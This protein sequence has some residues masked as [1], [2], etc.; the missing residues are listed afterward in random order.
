MWRGY[1]AGK[2]ANI[3]RESDGA[4]SGHYRSRETSRQ[5]QENDLPDLDRI[6]RSPLSILDGVTDPYNLGAW[7]A[8][9]RCRRRTCGNRAERLLRRNL[10][11]RR[12]CRLRRSRKRAPLIRV[13]NPART[14]RM[15]Q[16]EN[17]SGLSERRARLTIR[18]IRSKMP[19]RMALVMGA[20]GEGM[21]RSTREHCDG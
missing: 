14:M 21:R 7:F 12:R 9:R 6:T 11:R 5:Y 8:Q 10:T 16:E 20:E 19:G 4:A 15:L 17:K 2:T 1:P 18:C 3:R 13:T